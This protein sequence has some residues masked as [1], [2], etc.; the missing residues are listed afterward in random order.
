MTTQE[1]RRVFAPLHQQI[2]WIWQDVLGVDRPSLDDDFFSAGGSSLAAIRIIASVNEHF[3]TSMSA[4]TLFEAPTIALLA[5]RI[6]AGRRPAAPVVRLW[7]ARPGACMVYVPSAWGQDFAA[8]DFLRRLG[9]RALLLRS[10]GLEPGE[11][12]LTT[13][14]EI[15]DDSIAEL[16]RAAPGP[17]ILSGYSFGGNIAIEIARRAVEQGVEVSGLVLLDPPTA[18]IPP[19]QRDAHNQAMV[20]E[21]ALDIAGRI[22]SEQRHAIPADRQS[23]TPA[24]L[25]SALTGLSAREA[26]ETI[27]RATVGETDEDIV[28]HYVRRLSVFVNN[29]RT[30]SGVLPSAPNLRTIWVTSQDALPPER[31]SSDYEHLTLLPTNTDHGD[32]LTNTTL[33]DRIRHEFQSFIRVLDGEDRPVPVSQ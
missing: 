8:P 31:V 24:Q 6:Q 13:F 14:G 16:T 11:E 7:Q 15:V 29:V 26:V 23:V 4:G 33:P 3:G 20:R 22:I 18:E 30:V 27:L 21:G 32:L 9:L 5:E 1:Q 10:R 17:Y 2:A 25:S 19:E 12:P 28:G